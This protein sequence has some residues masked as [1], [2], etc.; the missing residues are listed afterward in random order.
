[1]KMFKTII[2]FFVSLVAV[3][4]LLMITLFHYSSKFNRNLF[5]MAS[6]NLESTYDAVSQIFS[7]QIEEKNN[8]LKMINLYLNDEKDEVTIKK[9]LKSVITKS[10]IDNFYFVNDNDFYNVDCKAIF[11]EA[12]FSSYGMDENFRFDGQ[13]FYFILNVEEKNYHNIKYNKI[14]ITYDEDNF[15]SNVSI[16]AYRQE[17][18]SGIFL[19]DGRLL[20]NLENDFWDYDNIFELLDQFEFKHNDISFAKD[21]NSKKYGTYELR[22]NNKDYYLHFK[23][24]I[25]D[26]VILIGLIPRQAMHLTVSKIQT[27]TIIM[28]SGFGGIILSCISLNVFLYYKKKLKIKNKELTTQNI[29]FQTL[30]E[31]MDDIFVLLDKKLKPVYVSPNSLRL[32]GVSP[33]EIKADINKMFECDAS[34][35]NPLINNAKNLKIGQSIEVERRL[36]NNAKGETYWCLDKLYHLREKNDDIYICI[37]SDRTKEKKNYEQIETALDVAKQANYAKTS[38]LANMSH[39]LRTPMNAILGFSNLLLECDDETKAKEYASKINSSSKILMDIINDIL[40]LD[41]EDSASS[42]TTTLKAIDLLEVKNVSFRYGNGLLVLENVALSIKRGEKIAIVGQ[43]GCGK[44]TLAKLFLRFYL[45]ESGHIQINGTNIDCFDLSSLRNSIAYISQNPFFFADTIRN[46]LTNGNEEI[47]D[48]QI[49]A[50]CKMCLANQFIETLPLGY[51]TVLSENGENL[52][53]GQRQKIALARALLA[54]PQI[55]ILDEATCN[56]DSVSEK[57]INEMLSYNF[58]NMSCI[59]IT[60]RLSTLEGCSKIYVMESGKIIG[61]GTHS[62]LMH[63]QDQYRELWN[64]Q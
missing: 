8:D 54:N 50:V 52:S 55:L 51:D 42:S 34:N 20:S 41:I 53:N 1:M 12:S 49:E 57:K 25:I 21:I 60:H 13:T 62:E 35:V 61:S 64:Q 36:R 5:N 4:S 2:F 27:D 11:N 58:S 32:I 28:L 44:S 59:F 46:N 14:A 43:S 37:L 40:D 48:E 16:K 30:S 17:C 63:S 15:L 33:I 6:N 45:P 22:Y 26:G 19:N 24:T 23:K 29:L 7:R 3:S 39:D 31:N 38:F 18:N 10:D 9:Y 47:S 56:L